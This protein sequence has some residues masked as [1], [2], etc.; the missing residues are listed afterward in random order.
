M[1]STNWKNISELVGIAAIVLGLFL[2][3]QEMRQSRTIARAQLSA[4]VSNM[5]TALLESERDPDFAAMLVKSYEN[6]GELTAAERLQLNAYLLEAVRAYI[7]EWHYCRLGI[8][9][10]WTA[11]IGTTAPEFFGSKYGQVY[12]AVRKQSLPDEMV[13]AIDEALADNA[14]VEFSRGFDSEVAEKIRQQ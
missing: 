1:K 9:E 13:A 5:W 4:E 2:V 7:R 3:Y 11:I 14:A 6:P 10:E 12:W 8:Y